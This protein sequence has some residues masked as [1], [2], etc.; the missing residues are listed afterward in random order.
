M[1]VNLTTNTKKNII[2]FI[3]LDDKIKENEK[4]IKKLKKEQ[5][6]LSEY[7]INYIQ[8]KDI[9]NLDIKVGN[10]KIR[11]IENHTK[12]GLSQQFLKE[13]IKEYFLC[14]YNHFDKNKCQ[15]ISEDIVK[16]I[17]KSR[18]VNTRISLKRLNI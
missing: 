8:E 6:K 16:F 10:S 14:K 13:K 15:L 17:N 7:L 12:T 1:S 9:K 5:K 4:L 2:N 11:Y 3:K 18:N